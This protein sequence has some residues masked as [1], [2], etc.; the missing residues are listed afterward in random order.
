MFSIFKNFKKTR[1]FG[2]DIGT[3]T[4]K[5][6]EISYKNGQ[7]FLENYGEVNLD[8]ACKESFRYFDKN[9]LNPNVDN[10]S[11]AIRELIFET[12]TKNKEVSF[13]LPDFSSFFSIF[14]MP[15]M[16][17]KEIDGAIGFE[18]RKYIPLPLAEVVLDWQS[19]E[20][21]IS[22]KNVNKVLVMAV[23]KVI[24]EHYK[25][26]SKK[27]GLVLLSLEPEAM[28]LKRSVVR[29]DKSETICI[30][31]IG[32][33]S[34]NV[35]I[36]E[37]GFMKISFSFDVSG[38][39]LT[40]AISDSLALDME[41][42]EASK[43][44]YG[45]LENEEFLLYPILEP[46]LFSISSK[47]REVIKDFEKKE[48]TLVEKVVFLGGTT[49]MPGIMDYFNKSLVREGVATFEIING[50]PFDNIV[51]PEG[52]E[53]QMDNLNANYA[54]ALGQALSKFE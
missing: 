9:T 35:S 26:I 6:V 3:K 33:Q 37:K 53:K 31:E 7:A 45:L 20:N 11:L 23:P 16:S 38:K 49:R 30:A 8:F 17:K 52:L 5:A 4:I 10:I 40:N 34:T 13:S 21:A 1:S 28:S 24:I 54:I 46:V 14:E 43:I 39:D 48:G 51:C 12:K 22:E 19:M 36:V 47:I 27:A 15:P 2:V 50:K 18:A 42:A 25:E 32:F 41:V 44:K 29:K